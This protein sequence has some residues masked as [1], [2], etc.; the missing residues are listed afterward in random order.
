M[1]PREKWREVRATDVA[2]DLRFGPNLIDRYIMDPKRVGFLF[3]RYAFAAK[4]LRNC[5]SIL[6]VGTGDGAAAVTFLTDTVAQTIVGIDF[7]ET[8]IEYTQNELMPAIALARPTDI[9]RIAFRC[10]DFLSFDHGQ[11]AGVASMD[12]IEHVAPEDSKA[13]IAHIADTLPRSGI[14]VVGTPNEYAAHLGSAHSRLGHVNNFTPER[15]RADLEKEFSAVFMFGLNDSTLHVGH[16]HLW[17]YI[18]A[19]CCKT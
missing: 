19:V 8:L 15:L 17:H 5:E 6:D 4:M 3:A 10:A 2:V 16:E 1:N 13:F 14:A 7:D 12:C 9:K 18:L 11:F